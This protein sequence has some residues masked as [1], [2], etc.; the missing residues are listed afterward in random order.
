MADLTFDVAPR[1]KDPITFD[2]GGDKHVYT[3]APPKQASMVL[4]VLDSESDIGA[5]KA[6]FQ[7]L[8]EGLSEEDQ[9]HL[10]AR[11]RDPEDDLDFDVLEDIV[12]GL[13]EKVSGRPTT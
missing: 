9:Q 8:D 5:A 11:L 7:W 6:A 2:L 13:V 3:F 1:R 10:E 12:T 4:K